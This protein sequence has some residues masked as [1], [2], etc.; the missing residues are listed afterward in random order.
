MSATYHYCTVR[1]LVAPSTGAWIEMYTPDYRIASVF[2][3][4]PSTGAWIEIISASSIAALIACV[5]PSTG[6][7]IE[8]RINNRR[9]TVGKSRTQHGCVD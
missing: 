9:N 5:A 2:G 7:W 6:A 4:A 1:H 3:V 8:I